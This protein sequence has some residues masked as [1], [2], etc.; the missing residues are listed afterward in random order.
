MCEWQRLRSSLNH[1]WLKN[2]YLKN[3]DGLIVRMQ[4]SR[5]IDV[6]LGNELSSYLS[7]WKRRHPEMEKLLST[8]EDRLSPRTLF[9]KEPL[10]HCSPEHKAWL[11][12]L[13][14]GLWLSRYDIR[15]RVGEGLE[16]LSEV[17]QSHDHLEADFQS[18]G[19]IASVIAAL[20]GFT[21]SIKKLSRL[22]SGFPDKVTTV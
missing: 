12:P 5:S 19:N 13:V 17:D 8:A 1:D 14:H 7:A 20:E 22:I 2:E 16:I 10:L 21:D 4:T 15:E 18:K 11:S 9:E 3:L 6:V